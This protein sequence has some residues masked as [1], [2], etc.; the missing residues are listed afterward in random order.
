MANTITG[1]SNL[2][3]VG[4][5]Q[6]AD[7]AAN[8]ATSAYGLAGSQGASGSESDRTDLSGSGQILGH[9]LQAAGS[10]SSFHSGL[11]RELKSQIASGTYR[12][13]PM[14][15]ARAVAKALNQKS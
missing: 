11:V 10:L 13:D 15:V 5:A 6:A 1:I 2:A 4:G 12:P 8:P 14:G 3:R 9:V 7:E